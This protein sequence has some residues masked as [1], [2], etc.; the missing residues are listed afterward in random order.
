MK[1]NNHIV[2]KNGKWAV[3]GEGAKKAKKTFMTRASALS[4]AYTESLEKDTCIYVH[5][6]SGKIRSVKCPK[7]ETPSLL[8]RFQEKYGLKY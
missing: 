8:K 5:D 4:Y 1:K 2:I 6:N 3:I 7:R